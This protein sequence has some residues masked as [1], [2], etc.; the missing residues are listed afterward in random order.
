MSTLFSS[1]T[2]DKILTNAGSPGC[3]GALARNTPYSPFPPTPN[4]RTPATTS[5]AVMAPVAPAVREC[6]AAPRRSSSQAILVSL[7]ACP[8]V[9]W[10][11]YAPGRRRVGD[12]CAVILLLGDV[13]ALYFTPRTASARTL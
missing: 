10:R 3:C 9:L 12:P 7:R 2:Q 5:G 13:H 6:Y 11:G 8:V 4:R 1:A